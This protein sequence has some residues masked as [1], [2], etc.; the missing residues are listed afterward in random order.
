MLKYLQNLINKFTKDF[1]NKLFSKYLDLSP[2]N[3]F[4]DIRNSKFAFDYIANDDYQLE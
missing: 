1:E 4:I 2:Y 3:I